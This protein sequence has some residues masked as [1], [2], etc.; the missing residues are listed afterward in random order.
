MEIKAAIGG[1][2]RRGAQSAVVPLHLA[3]GELNALQGL[4]GRAIKVVADLHCAANCGGQLWGEI[5]FLSFNT[6]CFDFEPDRAAAG[7]RRGAVDVLVASDRG[8]NV[9]A[10]AADRF[11]IPPQEFARFCVHTYQALLQKLYVLLDG[12]DLDDDCR[13]VS[14]LVA[15]G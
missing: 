3:G 14:S 10:V 6:A 13:G 15:F 4:R 8:G 11:V 9:G 5:D 1:T 12:T 7:A 2:E